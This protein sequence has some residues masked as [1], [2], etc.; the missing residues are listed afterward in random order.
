MAVPAYR[1]AI[2][3]DPQ[4]ADA[5]L[6]LGNVYLEMN[7]L[8]QAAA[9]FKKALEIDPAME[10]AQRGL[11]KTQTRREEAKKSSGPFGRLVDPAKVAPAAGPLG[12]ELSDSERILDRK[13]LFTLLSQVQTDLQEVLDCLR[14]S[15]NPAMHTLNR[16]LT[17]QTSMHGETLSKTEALEQFQQAHE[18]FAPR[19]QQFRRVLQQLREHEAKVK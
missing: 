8:V 1:E 14:G 7:N 3:L 11:E 4:M 16:L 15:I 19:L 6:N 10:R 13:T 9:Q 5:Y 17:H 12:R 18:A 2:R